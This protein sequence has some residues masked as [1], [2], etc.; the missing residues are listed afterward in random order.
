VAVVGGAVARPERVFSPLPSDPTD[1][2]TCAVASQL[3]LCLALLPQRAAR[4]SKRQIH[5]P[6]LLEQWYAIFFFFVRVLPD[7][8]SLHLCTPKVCAAKSNVL[9]SGSPVANPKPGPDYSSP[10]Y[11]IIWFRLP[12]NMSRT[13][14]DTQRFIT[15]FTRARCCPCPEQDEFSS[16][17]PTARSSISVLL[18][19]SIH[20]TGQAEQYRCQCQ[21]H[22]SLSLLPGLPS[23]S[24]YSEVY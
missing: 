18:V 2:S 22:L 5:V 24:R 1:V 21:H 7:V 14:W 15:V 8:I 16:L 11:D 20:R 23:V 10:Y 6:Y 4:C 17:S 13:P 19:Y 3:L 12:L 9:T